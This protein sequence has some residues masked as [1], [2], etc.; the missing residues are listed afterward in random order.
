MRTHERRREILERQ[1]LDSIDDRR[2]KIFVPQADDKG[3][4]FQV[5]VPDTAEAALCELER[6]ALE[7][8]LFGTYPAFS[9][10]P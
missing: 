5:D 7:V 2:W 3:L 9:P 1:P 10:R 8:R 6:A 4:D